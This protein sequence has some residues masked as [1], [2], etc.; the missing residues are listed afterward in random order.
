MYNV[1]RCVAH[2]FIFLISFKK[3]VLMFSKLKA[4]IRA[5]EQIQGGRN[6]EA[7]RMFN[8]EWHKERILR[9]GEDDGGGG[10]AEAEMDEAEVGQQLYDVTYAV[11]MC[12]DKL[13]S[14][15]SDSPFRD[16]ALNPFLSLLFGK[17]IAFWHADTFTDNFKR[18]H[19]E[20]SVGLLDKI[21]YFDR[22]DRWLT[23]ETGII[24]EDSFGDILRQLTTENEALLMAEGSVLEGGSRK[25]PLFSQKM[26]DKIVLFLGGVQPPVKRPSNQINNSDEKSRTPVENPKRMNTRD[27]IKQILQVQN[28]TKQAAEQLKQSLKFARADRITTK[29]AEADR[30]ADEAKQKAAEAK[31]KAEEA[32]RIASE[33]A[34]AERQRLAAEQ[35]EAKRLADEAKAERQRLAAEA[36]RIADEAKQKADETNRNAAWIANKETAEQVKRLADEA[37]AKAAEAK[38]LAD[39]GA[40]EQAKQLADEAEKLAAEAERQRLAANLAETRTQLDFYRSDSEF[41]PADEAIQQAAVATERAEE[42]QTTINHLKSQLDTILEQRDTAYQRADEAQTT[43]NHLSSQLD[44]Q[45]QLINTQQQLLQTQQ[46]SNDA[47][48]SA[49]GTPEAKPETEQ[50][51]ICSKCKNLFRGMLSTFTPSCCGGCTTFLQHPLLIVM[52][53]TIVLDRYTDLHLGAIPQQWI[54]PQLSDD[55]FQFTAEH[56]KEGD[57]YH[58]LPFL[59]FYGAISQFLTASNWN[60][61]FRKKAEKWLPSS[62][63]ATVAGVKMVNLF[64]FVV[65][66]VK[67]VTLPNILCLLFA[68]NTAWFAVAQMSRCFQAAT[69][70]LSPAIDDM[71]KKFIERLAKMNQENDEIVK[72]KI[73]NIV[74]ICNKLKDEPFTLDLEQEDQEKYQNI[75]DPINSVVSGT[76][77]LA[78]DTIYTRDNG[79]FGRIWNNQIKIE[80]NVQFG[81]T[82]DKLLHAF[83]SA[84]NQIDELPLVEL[85]ELEIVPFQF[86]LPTYSENFKHFIHDNLMHYVPDSLEE[87][88]PYF[89]DLGLSDGAIEI[90]GST[91]SIVLI[92]LVLSL[93]SISLTISLCKYPF[94]KDENT[95]NLETIKQNQNT[96]INMIRNSKKSSDSSD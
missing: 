88:F 73:N 27:T 8:H 96:I 89:Q 18:F 47:N 94:R 41:M 20:Y 74:T 50:I 78:L 34:E 79:I 66:F 25:D 65:S 36:A 90:L 58:F 26:H 95:T 17:V 24:L 77:V 32:D 29:K 70:S 38:R 6:V 49:E 39:E 54:I 60:A 76:E 55:G 84:Y 75:C 48:Q 67:F 22:K 44:T 7:R 46:P 37:K 11:G 81:D 72:N 59:Q 71:T 12:L 92:L 19:V 2:I 15:L 16:F 85:D 63:A 21:N 52:V 42:A 3:Q 4:Q 83:D 28:Q 43:I 45:Q 5:F 68:V 61:H 69:L 9:G 53:L 62:L 31:R 23:N 10:S 14:I 1:S 91:P 51:D 13:L 56:F 80:G 33:Q 57:Y 30:K 86:P 87:Y 35:A 40:V 64:G 82:A 93:Y